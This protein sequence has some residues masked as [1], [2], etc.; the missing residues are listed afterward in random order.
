VG[1]EHDASGA[2][3]N[4]Q[5]AFQLDL[6]GRDRYLTLLD[7]LLGSAAFFLLAPG[8]LEQLDDLFVRGLGEVP[9]PEAYGPEVRW[10]LQADE[11]VDLGGE[12]LGRLGGAHGRGEDEAPR[13]SA[14]QGLYG[15]PGRHPG[16]EAVVHQDHGSSP[17]L[18]LGTVAAEVPEPALHLRRLPLCDPLDVLVRDA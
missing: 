13:P 1:E 4:T 7:R 14:P 10:R 3:R 8:P 12:Q 18:R 17:D 16:R 6:P 2:F 11:L 5:V 9:V 15:G